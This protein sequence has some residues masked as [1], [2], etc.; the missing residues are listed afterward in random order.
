MGPILDFGHVFSNIGYII[1]GIAYML[2]VFY[3]RKNHLDYVNKYMEINTT[4]H[5]IIHPNDTGIPEQFGIYFAMATASIGEGILSACF[6]ICPTNINFQFDTTFMYALSVLIF[7]KVFQFR[8]SDITPSPRISYL[9]I[10]VILV[11]EVIG[12]F[13]DNII[14]WIFFIVFYLGIMFY[15]IV[16]IY[17]T[18]GISSTLEFTW[19]NLK[20]ILN[21]TQ[22][23]LECFQLKPVQLVIAVNV[24]LAIYILFTHSPGVSSYI[25]LILMLN[26]QMY[27]MYYIY[28]KLWYACSKGLEGEK[29]SGITW[30]YAGLAIACVAASG[31]NIAVTVTVHHFRKIGGCLATSFLPWN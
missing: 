5:G 10:S 18:K 6:H 27:F 14:F 2:I 16:N 23:S 11:V 7:L 12:Y 15:A 20:K 4:S 8:H 28:C 24:F 9:L 31:R 21:P 25:L 26:M 3:R 17:C 22:W 29:I 13:V 30:A 1:F 19:E